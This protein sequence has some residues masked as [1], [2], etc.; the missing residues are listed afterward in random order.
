MRV[1]KRKSVNELLA[2]DV[3]T[4]SDRGSKSRSILLSRPKFEKADN[5]EVYFS[6]PSQF[7]PHKTHIVIIY[8]S[9]ITEDSS[10]DEIKEIVQKEDIKIA[11]SCEAFLYQG[12][13][14]ISYKADAGIDKEDRPP[15]KRNPLQ[16]GMACKHIL[17][18]LRYLGVKVV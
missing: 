15:I 14:Y 3:Y 6:V 12:F 18:V 8:A 16:K 13:K 1:F 5:K 9:S 11:C 7:R 10:L 4:K 2:R 17:S